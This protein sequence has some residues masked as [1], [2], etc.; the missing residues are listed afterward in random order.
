MLRKIAFLVYLS[1]LTWVG[2]SSAQEQ[3]LVT[4]YDLGMAAIVDPA[5]DN[6][7]IAVPLQG[8]VALPPGDD[9]APLVVILHGRHAMC[10]VN[11]EVYPCEPGEE[12]HYALGFR[13]LMQ[14]LAEQGYAVLALNLNPT[15]TTAYGDGDADARTAQLLDLHMQAL[16][17]AANGQQSGFEIPLQGRIDFSRI[18]LIGHSSGGGAAL[19]ITRAQTYSVDGLLLIAAAYNALGPEG[20]QR[21]GE[22]LY[23]YYRTPSDVPVAVLLPD[24]DGDQT[25]FTSQIAYEAAR[26]DSDRRAFAASVRL[27]RANHNHF[28]SAVERGDRRFGYTPCFGETTD[29]MPRAEQEKFLVDYVSAFLAS[30][31]EGTVHPAFDPL[32][33][34]TDHLF[35]QKVEM[36]L[37]V[38]AAQRQVIIFPQTERERTVNQLGGAVKAS[39]RSGILFCPPGDVC[40]AGITTMGRFGYLRLSYGGRGAFS[41]ELPEAYHDLS[42]YAM[43][44]LRAVPDYTST[45]NTAG[46]NANFA[47]VLTDAAGNEDEVW[48]HDLSFQNIPVPAEY[49]AY[50][51]FALY[52]ASV[53]LPLSA[54][55]VDRTQVISITL[56]ALDTSGTLLLADLELIR[57]PD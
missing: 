28:N 47:V 6:L 14:A 24:C 25:Q 42:A 23:T 18:A 11:I 26:L 33:P 36:N 29:I 43:L 16:G 10:G 3:P 31:W 17:D 27:F 49:Y 39:D 41:F 20:I 54:F 1:L 30:I 53:R 2:Q 8:A 19:T 35:G 40:L 51:P 52:P 22:E 38:P 34:V 4:P 45:L 37:S 56:R 46:T 5:L 7:E 55:E 50:E 32:L 15:L 48:V 13:Y 9:A 57:V 21:T 12:I 44:H